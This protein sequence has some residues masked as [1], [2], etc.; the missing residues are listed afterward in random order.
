MSVM[1]A[2]KAGAAAYGGKPLSKQEIGRM[3]AKLERVL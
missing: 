3:V 1:L 2:L